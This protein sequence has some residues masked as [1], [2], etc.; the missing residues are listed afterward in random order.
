MI[1]SGIVTAEVQGICSRKRVEKSVFVPVR[2]EL[3]IREVA[4]EEAPMAYSVSGPP[5]VIGYHRDEEIRRNS[6]THQ[7]RTLDDTLVFGGFA[8][9]PANGG[10]PDADVV[11]ALPN[12]GRKCVARP[13]MRTILM[14][15][16]EAAKAA[17]ATAAARTAFVTGHGL[18][19]PCDEMYFNASLN[20][21]GVLHSLC[22][23]QR[24][25]DG[26]DA[27]LHGFRLDQFDEI[28]GRAE[29]NGTE[30]ALLAKIRTAYTVE[31]F[32]PQALKFDPAAARLRWAIEQALGDCRSV[33]HR[34]QS[35]TIA[36][37]VAL[38]DAYRE[39]GTGDLPQI[40]AMIPMARDLMDAAGDD[41]TMRMNG[42]VLVDEIF[43][44]N[45]HLVEPA[46][47]K[48][49]FDLADLEDIPDFLGP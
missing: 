13:A 21:D 41:G 4:I 24:R 5:Y 23:R 18:L 47:A 10:I 2:A 25:R 48:E 20:P 28:L 32:R 44:L 19:T 27:C 11:L 33:L 34:L 12:A 46:Q 35:E 14:D 39:A 37:W 6:R 15:G 16:R 7:A 49:R 26:A 42:R 8:Q 9:I 29:E 43:A 1:A 36:K 38:R 22:L 31:V 40:A 30:A 3:E 17:A 45:E